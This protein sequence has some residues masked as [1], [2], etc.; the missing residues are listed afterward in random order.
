MPYTNNLFIQ[1][2]TKQCL[3]ASITCV[4]LPSLGLELQGQQLDHLLDQMDE[5]ESA[6]F[7]L[8]PAD[9]EACEI[10]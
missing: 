8:H 9:F 4:A 10:R 3:P 7:Q 1:I 5:V 6:A 2:L